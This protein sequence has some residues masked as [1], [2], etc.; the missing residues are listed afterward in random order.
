MEIAV[1]GAGLAGCECALRLARAGIRVALFEQKPERFSPAHSSAEVAELVCS[2]SFRSNEPTTGVGLLKEEMRALGSAIMAAADETR[3]PAGKA[4]AVDRLLFSRAVAR[5]LEAEPNIRL[6]RREITRLDDPDLARADRVI[7]AAGP[8][9]SD[10]LSAN[11]AELTGRQLYFYDALAPIVLG[12]SVNMDIAFA[13]T[14]GADPADDTG[15]YL[16]CP[17]DKEEYLAFCAALRDGRRVPTRDFEK[18]IHFEGCM[19]IESL[20][21]RGDRTLSFGPLKPVG[22][23][24]PRSGRR[25]WA[26]VQLRAENLSRTAFNLVG[27]QTKLMQSEQ[28]RI[29]RLIPGLEK[30][31]FLRYGSMHRNTYIDAPKVLDENLALRAAPRIHLAGQISGVEGY[32]ES[33][34]CGLWLGMLLAAR[35]QGRRLA[36]PP[37]TSALGALLGHLRRPTK[38]FQPSNIHFGLMPEPEERVKKKERRTYLAGRS[39][40]AFAAW[41]A[42]QE[43]TWN[44]FIH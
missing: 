28:E 12:D 20:A 7:I 15:D 8:L 25:P 23:V 11:L 39:R 27:C 42:E 36:P 1:A 26:L 30:A 3:V 6:I 14:R 21:D 32:V 10:A 40:A 35:H 43:L 37:P 29:F 5:R 18:E 13:G 41:K 34:A 31:E 17:M 4:L 33:A 22:F 24:D 44:L 19:P 2:N 16:N 9:A 38:H